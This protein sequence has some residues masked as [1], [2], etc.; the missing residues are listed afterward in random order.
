MGEFHGPLGTAKN[1][2]SELHDPFGK[3]ARR[4]VWQISQET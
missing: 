1:S 2:L 4:G 3:P